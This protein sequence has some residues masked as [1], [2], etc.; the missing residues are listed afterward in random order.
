MM[1]FLP[2]DGQHCTIN[3][4]MMPER[5]ENMYPSTSGCPRLN[6]IIHNI[7][8]NDPMILKY[9]K[10]I[11]NPLQEKLEKI[12]NSFHSKKKTS[13]KKIESIEAFGHS[14]ARK[15]PRWEGINNTIII[16]TAHGKPVP[17]G[18]TEQDMKVI[19]DYIGMK[20]KRIWSGDYKY[21]ENWKP[22]EA[23]KLGIGRF[24]QDLLTRLQNAVKSYDPKSGKFDGKPFEIYM[25]HDTTLVPLFNVF[26]IYDGKWPAMG[27][28][29]A[30]ELYVDQRE[31]F[32]VRIVYS[33][34]ELK[35]MKFADFEKQAQQSIP[36]D[37]A[38]ECM[39][40]SAN[41]N[42]IQTL[43]SGQ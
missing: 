37:H 4:H 15:F 12:F 38:K 35:M 33:G 5:F 8:H 34:K 14:N 7:E 30:L 23:L 2:S 24:V 28:N 27:S 29:L 31:E 19:Q 1:S 40:R 41:S 3:I 25:G 13:E 39:T 6:Q 16:L 22:N 9:E 42:R 43:G 32:Y 10:E 20:Q 11:M 17:T 26:D 18:I 36:V 21:D